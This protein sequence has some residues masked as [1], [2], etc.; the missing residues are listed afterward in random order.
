MIGSGQ[1]RRTDAARG[2]MA[3]LLMLALGLRALLAPGIM[4]DFT[5]DA[6]S[7]ITICTLQ[8]E[9]TL[10]PDGGQGSHAAHAVAPCLFAA[11]GF[12]NLGAVTGPALSAPVEWVP[13]KPVSII[14]TGTARFGPDRAHARGPPAVIF[15]SSLPGSNA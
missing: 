3:W 9:R 12:A 4:P 10:S 7:L 1:Q 2:A 14:E 8:G 13:F 5:A 11:A 15:L 6:G